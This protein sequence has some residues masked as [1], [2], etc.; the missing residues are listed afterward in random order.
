MR[1]HLVEIHTTHDRTNIRHGKDDNGVI[2]LRHLVARLGGIEHLIESNAVDRHARIVLGD[3]LLLRNIHHLLH[4]VHLLADPI[5][6]RNDQIEAGL[7]RA[8]VTAKTLDSPIET[9]R[10]GLYAS[11]QS[12][13]NK[14][15]ENDCKNVKSK[16]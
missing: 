10:N 12:E 13:N 8:G 9:L 1:Q 11:E 14:D 3:D 16:E 7:K 2:E 15:Q 6:E 5:E 4:H